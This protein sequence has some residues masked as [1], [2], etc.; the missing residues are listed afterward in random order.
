MD[1]G[2][3]IDCGCFG[4]AQSNSVG[5]AI[6][7]ALGP[8]GDYLGHETAGPGTIIRDLVLLLMGL[9]LFFVPSI[10]SLD[11]LRSRGKY[12]EVEQA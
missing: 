4:G 2:L 12:E 3:Q 7:T 11:N 6:M 5:L 1:A 8:I 9:H 10:F